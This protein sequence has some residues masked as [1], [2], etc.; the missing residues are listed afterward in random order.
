MHNVTLFRNFIEDQRTSMEIYADQLL[1]NLQKLDL[2][3]F[4]FN[5]YRPIFGR[6]TNMLTDKANLRMRTARYFDYPLQAKKRGGTVNHILDHGYAHLLKVLDPEM[7]VITVHDIIP[8]LASRGEIKG[9]EKDRKRWL[10]EYTARFYKMARHII[11]ISENT[12]NDLI[13]YC[14]CKPE[15]ITVIYYGIN[16]VFKPVNTLEK[17]KLRQ[18]FNLPQDNTKLILI[19]GEAF[20]KNR[21]TSLKVLERLACNYGSAIGL[22]S[23]GRNSPDW[24]YAI[25]NSPQ[26]SKVIHIDYLS[27]EDMLRLYN[28]VDCLLFP[29]WYE[30][31]GIPPLEA[32]ACG[33]PVVTSNAASLPEAVGDAGL[34]FAPDDVTGMTDA[35]ERLLKDNEFRKDQV[36]KGLEHVKNFNWTKNITETLEVYRK[37]IQK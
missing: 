3:F 16:P 8:L 31:F 5:E 35:I 34:V 14:D 15:S 37:I 22:V 33:I 20:Y 7:T 18:L 26:R 4:H 6:L 24:N 30:G 32:M 28:A 27:S 17:N 19:V 36:R 13:Q 25:T 23:L 12:K 2:D 21:Y 29:S 9:V 1:K 10:S 11:A